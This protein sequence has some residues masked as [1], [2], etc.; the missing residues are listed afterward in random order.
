[1]SDHFDL[2]LPS[3]N[4]FYHINQD[5]PSSS[6]HGLYA[7][8]TSDPERRKQEKEFTIGSIGFADSFGI[9]CASMLAVPMEIGLCRAQVGRGKNLCTQL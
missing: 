9:L 4:V 7:A 2:G 5:R 3:V 1:M 6:S 8:E